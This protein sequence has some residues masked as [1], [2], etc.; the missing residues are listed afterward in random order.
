MLK[1]MLLGQHIPPI[2]KRSRTKNKEQSFH[3]LQCYI[4]GEEEIWTEYNQL[5]P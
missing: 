2:R 5:Y 3:T 1:Q 4:T